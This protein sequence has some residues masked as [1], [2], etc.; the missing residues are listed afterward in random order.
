MRFSLRLIVFL[1][2]TLLAIQATT[3]VT[4]R[5][6]LRN[7]LVEDGRAQVAASETRFARQLD[8]LEHQLAEG[9]R[10][11]TLDF[12]LRQAIADRDTAT[13][14][15]AL[16]NHGR[17]VGASRMLLIA[18]DGTIDG[19]T[20]AAP[21]DKP[22]FFPDPALLDTA[23]TDDHAGS[24]AVLGGKPV[25][26]VAVPVLAPD[27]I[28]FVA[29][30]LPLDDAELTRLREA[31]GIAGKI[32]L[33][34]REPTGWAVLA[35]TVDASVLGQLPEPGNAVAV[36]GTSGD[37]AI[38]VSH[39]M[40]TLTGTAPVRV[41]LDYPLSD[42]LRR[43]ERLSLVLLPILFVGLIATMAGVAVISRG[44]ARPLEAL[45][46][47]TERIA[48][49]DYTPP[50]RLLRSDELG[51]LSTALG[52]MTRAIAEREDDIRHQATHDP[53]TGLPNRGA[54]AAAIAARSGDGALAVLVI[55]MIRWPDIAATVGR[56]IGD[57]VLCDSARRLR[58]LGTEIARA[59]IVGGVGE[60]TFAIL[61]EDTAIVAAITAAARIAEAFETP[62]HE[63]DLAIDNPV[64]IGIAML[65]DHGT[66]APQLL[67][68]AEVALT[69]AA[70]GVETRIAVY[71]PETD[72]HRPERL[73][74]MSDLRAGLTR[75][76][77]R[78]FYQPKLDLRLNRITG[79][80]ALVRWDHPTR[81]RVFPDD[82]VAL[83]E[84]TGNIQHL[85]R[86]A[87]RAGLSEAK[88]WRDRGLLAR[89]AINLSVRDLADPALAG[90]IAALRR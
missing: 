47:Q 59:A 7:T 23:A 53:I 84:E 57:R 56:D 19:D 9:V 10:L 44:V 35:G 52:A 63:G 32:G 70:T 28:A 60:N 17:R 2:A 68:R 80:E 5:T 81:G 86:W 75:G 62:W 69:A 30:A 25:W 83:A 27:L 51:Q 89:V 15:S 18:P 37:E 45:A 65:P 50:A 87:L 61:L 6:V 34:I 40:K 14:V 43:Y 13:V 8:E 55:G 76:E 90:R 38:A 42:A 88:G 3:I 85:T 39:A 66:A 82:F 26:L 12:A 72:P 21:S 78:L 73:S 36:A 46:R 74:L 29:A 11:L 64:A 16:R 54:V 48:L 24:V 67:R 71:R 31:A 1:A 4:V 77:F 22:V 33:T 79:A 49:G 58:V 41:V 20:G